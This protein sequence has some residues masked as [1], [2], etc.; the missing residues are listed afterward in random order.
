[1]MT[2]I[3]TAHGLQ[4]RHYP[5]P[6]TNTKTLNSSHRFDDRGI[7][8]IFPILQMRK[9]GFAGFDLN[10]DCTQSDALATMVYSQGGSLM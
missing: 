4:V 7:V 5:K 10:S 1:M 3:E 2:C 6:F 9:T 8:S